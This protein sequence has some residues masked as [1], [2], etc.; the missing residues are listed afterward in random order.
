ML[1]VSWGKD[2]EFGEDDLLEICSVKSEDL[3]LLLLLGF[4]IFFLFL[5][6]E[7]VEWGD[8]IVVLR[9]FLDKN[10]DVN[11]KVGGYWVY[12]MV[13]Y[14]V[15]GYGYFEVVRLFFKV[16]LSLYNWN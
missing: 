7:V 4:V 13:L 15:V 8:F 6:Y 14:W 16:S 12:R 11:E 5:L 10:L 9:L 2:F 3:N 1:I